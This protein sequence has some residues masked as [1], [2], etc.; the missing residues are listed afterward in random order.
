MDVVSSPMT[1]K[2]RI[3]AAMRHGIPDRVPVYPG[4]G[5]WY[6]A[7]ITGLTMWDVTLGDPDVL[8]ELMLEMNRRYGYDDWF[9]IASGL[10]GGRRDGISF[11]WREELVR[12]T[13]E[14]IVKRSWVDTPYGPLERIVVYPKHDPAWEIEKPIKDIDRDWPRLRALLGEDWLWKRELPRWHYRLGDR[15]VYPLGVALP[16]DWWYDWRD[17]TVQQLIY[18]LVDRRDKMHEILDYYHDYAMVYLQAALEVRPDEIIL[19]G[20]TSSL[21]VLSPAL[22]R[23][24]NLP[25]VKEVTRLCKQAG[26]VSHQHSCGRSRGIVEMS[27]A[28]TDLD[29]MEPLERHPGG[30]VDLAE[31]KRLYGYKLCLKGNINTFD[32]LLRGTPAEVEAEARACIEAGAAG[33]GF[34][35]STGDQAGRDTPEEN[36]WAMIEAAHKYGRY[37]QDGN[38]HP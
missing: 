32:M 23:E 7:R 38:R 18:D 14:E 31:V 34:W 35:L 19:A 37:D 21:S 20:S 13:G 11:E 10:E 27:Y 24:Y 5:P 6:A 29:V 15:G 22:Y 33:G 12:R 28:E 8:P 16:V 4:L 17:G 26:V 3:L 1:P 2:Q 25:F 9:W 30:D 36:I